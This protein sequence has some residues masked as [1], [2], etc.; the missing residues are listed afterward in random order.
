MPS[1]KSLSGLDLLKYAHLLSFLAFFNLSICIFL[2]LCNSF[3]IFSNILKFVTLSLRPH[4]NTR[5][6]SEYLKKQAIILYGYH[7]N[8]SPRVSHS[9]YTLEFDAFRI[10]YTKSIFYKINKNFSRVFSQ[11]TLLG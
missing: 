8:T 11:S 6:L 2:S 1:M 9:M 4:L 10:L 5:F 3:G 7:S